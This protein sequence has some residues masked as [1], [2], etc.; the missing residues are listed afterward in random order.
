MGFSGCGEEY[1]ATFKLRLKGI[2]PEDT[3]GMGELRSTWRYV[4]KES[5]ERAEEREMGSL[6]EIWIVALYSLNTRPVNKKKVVV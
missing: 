4:D 6:Y 2:R 1:F 5:L 3:V